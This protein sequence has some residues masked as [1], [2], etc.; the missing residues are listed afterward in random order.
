MKR[1]RLTRMPMALALAGLLTFASVTACEDNLGPDPEVQTFILIFP[2]NDSVYVDLTSGVIGSGPITMFDDAAFTADFLAPD[3]SPDGRV[4]EGVF[5]LDVDV[6][7][8]TITK[9]S[10]ISGGAFS[11]TLLKVAT[12]STTITFSLVRESDA[13]VL[14][15]TQIPVDVN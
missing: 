10:R 11:G 9:F 13:G 7:D 4:I 12:G 3:G 6:L 14:F 8:T 15:A 1:S 2:G 5:R